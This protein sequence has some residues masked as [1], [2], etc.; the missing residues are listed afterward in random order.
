MSV[1]ESRTV[2][3][4]VKIFYTLPGLVRPGILIFIL[5]ISVVCGSLVGEL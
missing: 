3:V 4:C 1:L 2:A 5:K